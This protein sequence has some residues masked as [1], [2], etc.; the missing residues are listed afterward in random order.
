[1]CVTSANSYIANLIW[2]GDGKIVCC[3]SI[4]KIATTDKVWS[5][6]SAQPYKQGRISFFVVQS[7]WV[8]ATVDKSLDLSAK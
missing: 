2:S 5:S 8:L 1:M 4:K 3:Q 7:V 6:T